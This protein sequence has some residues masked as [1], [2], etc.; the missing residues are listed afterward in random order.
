[1][2]NARIV[3]PLLAL[4][5]G[6]A[7]YYAWQNT[8]QLQQISVSRAEK[9]GSGVPIVAKTPATRLDFTGGEKRRFQPPRKNLFGPLFSPPPAPVKPKVVIK[10]AVPVPKAVVVKPQIPSP[11][12]QPSV[13]RMPSFKLLGFLQKRDQ[14]TAFVS[15]NNK[16]YLVKKGQPF[17]DY[18]QVTEFTRDLLTIART[19]GSAEVSLSLRQEPERT[20]RSRR[21][22]YVPPVRSTMPVGHP[23]LGGEN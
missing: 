21:P 1:M 14:L 11:P 8:P 2:K 23:P 17:A 12:P 3:L 16:V 15:L 5:A 20:G 6:G 18:Y 9:G 19:D 10:K 22:A 7:F 13:V 4:L